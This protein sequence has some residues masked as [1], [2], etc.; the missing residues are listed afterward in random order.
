MCYCGIDVAKRKHVIAL[1]DETGHYWWALYEGLTH[2]DHSVVVLNALQVHAFRKS[3]V[4]KVKSD[5]T[6][7]GLTCYQN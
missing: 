3:G 6:D 1:L 5:R 7:V 2:H 4:R